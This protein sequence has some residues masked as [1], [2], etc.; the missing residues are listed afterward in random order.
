MA[1]STTAKPAAAGVVAGAEDGVPTRKRSLVRYAV[2]GLLLV[3]VLGGGL[4]GLAPWLPAWARLSG[5]AAKAE[6]KPEPPVTH[7]VP[8]SNLVV[9]LGPPEGKRYL[10]IG[11]ELGVTSPKHAKDVEEHK[12]QITDLII[13]ALAATPVQAL[14]DEDGRNELKRLLV[15]KIH[16]ELGLEAVRRVY[17]TEFVIQ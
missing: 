6:A 3:A 9:N 17:F 11:I 12:S 8:V 7:T 14:G 13:S 16:E 10:K 15:E 2:I 1:T 4:W 5:P